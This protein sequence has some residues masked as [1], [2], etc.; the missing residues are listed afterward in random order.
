MVPPVL[1]DVEEESADVL[2]GREG[3][4]VLWVT[5]KVAVMEGDVA[6]VVGLLAVGWVYS[7][8]RE[9]GVAVVDVCQVP[10]VEADGVIVD[11]GVLPVEEL[12]EVVMPV[13][14]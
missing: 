1:V 9:D 11:V 7:V 2:V 8:L 5:V 14:L 4:G 3:V 6:E 13:V 12:S 10:E